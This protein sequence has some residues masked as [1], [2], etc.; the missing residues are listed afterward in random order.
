[1]F[2][3]KWAAGAPIMQIQRIKELLLYSYDEAEQGQNRKM[4]SFH[5][6]VLKR[7]ARN[8]SKV[9][10]ARAARIFF[11]IRPIKF[12]LCDVRS[13]PLPLTMLKLY[14]LNVQRTYFLDPLL[15]LLIISLL[16]LESI[17]QS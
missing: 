10:A 8:Y 16:K 14:V 1:M 9:R 2:L 15:S 4:W 13:L 3:K 7:T 6:V 12:L 17:L 5:V 11:A